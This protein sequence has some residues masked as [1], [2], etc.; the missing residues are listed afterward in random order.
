MTEDDVRRIVREE[1]ERAKPLTHFRGIPLPPN[2]P[3]VVDYK[4]DWRFPGGIPGATSD[5]SAGRDVWGG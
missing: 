3:V 1:I 5:A 4:P 2:S